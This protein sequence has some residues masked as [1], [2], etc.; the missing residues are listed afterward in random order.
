MTRRTRSILIDGSLGRMFSNTASSSSATSANLIAGTKAASS[1]T[2]IK[3]KSSALTVVTAT[4]G[5]RFINSG[6]ITSITYK[7]DGAATQA[8]PAGRAVIVR[9]RKVSSNGTSTNI[10]NYTLPVNVLSGT[11]TTEPIAIT[12]DD[13]FFWDVT[14]VGTTRP[15]QGLYITMTYY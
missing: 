1:I 14:Q 2:Y 7:F 9:L 8:A 5:A 3:P 4:K 15:G 12:A 13:S 11:I 6:L 10:A